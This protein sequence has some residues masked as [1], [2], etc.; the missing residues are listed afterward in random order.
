MPATEPEPEWLLEDT[1]RHRAPTTRMSSRERNAV[2]L[3]VLLTNAMTSKHRDNVYIIDSQR[4]DPEASRAAQLA[5]VDRL[6]RRG[7]VLI[8]M[9]DQVQGLPPGFDVI[10]LGHP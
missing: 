9:G 3:A 4:L 1:K 5:A 7:Q 6:T 8:D 2:A 10:D